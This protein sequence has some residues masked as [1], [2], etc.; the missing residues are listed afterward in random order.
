MTN[1]NTEEKR[2]YRVERMA[3]SLSLNY[4]ID[5]V[6]DL[7][8][9][10]K[11]LEAKSKLEL[12]KQDALLGYL[13]NDYDYSMFKIWDYDSDER[14]QANQDG[15]KI[16]KEAYRKAYNY[17]EELEEEYIEKKAK[18]YKEFSEN[19]EYKANLEDKMFDEARGV[20]TRR[21]GD[22]Y[23]LEDEKNLSKEEILLNK[24]I[25][26]KAYTKEM[27]KVA[28]EEAKVMDELS[29]KCTEQIES[30]NLF[31]NYKEA[32]ES[33]EYEEAEEIFTDIVDEIKENQKDL[34]E[35]EKKAF[36][37]LVERIFKDI[38]DRM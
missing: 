32:F 24:R 21:L 28:V 31:E 11:F 23:L 4:F 27:D 18:E 13:P 15:I 20:L 3:H 19:K 34:S 2:N 5:T 29:K 1:L 16:I 12:V 33:E 10:N 37:D 9:K 36:A 26:R 38:S 8:K 25:I 35:N 30:H 17:I 6:N 14:T 22:Y 7:I